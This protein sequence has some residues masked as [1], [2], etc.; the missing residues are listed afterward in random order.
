MKTG[1]FS[2]LAEMPLLTQV[3]IGRLFLCDA[4]RWWYSFNYF[5]QLSDCDNSPKNYARIFVP[6]KFISKTSALLEARDSGL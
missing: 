4:R 1:H 5:A 6:A 2:D 3:S